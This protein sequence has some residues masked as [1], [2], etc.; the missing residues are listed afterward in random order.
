MRRYILIMAFCLLALGQKVIFAEAQDPQKLFYEAGSFYEKGDYAKAAETY[1][2]ILD[3]GVESGNLYYNIGNGFLKMGNV[4]YAILCYEKAKRFIPGDGD[5]KSNLEYARSMLAAE[6]PA[7]RADGL[8][9]RGIKQPFK[10]LNLNAF[11]IFMALFYVFVAAVT[12][13]LLSNAVIGRRFSPLY[14]VIIAAFFWALA[15]YSLRFYDEAVVHHGIVLQ[16]IVEARYEPIDKSDVYFKVT[17]AQK[18]AVVKTRNG[19]RQIRRFDGKIGWVK[20]EAVEEI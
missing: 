9:V 13:G 3:A 5:L 7:I 12:A 19:W 10:D 14:A 15:A 20:R 11:T 2:R 17:D 1:L 6:D 4:S 8:I 18:V 16:K